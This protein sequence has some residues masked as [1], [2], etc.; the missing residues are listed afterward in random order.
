MSTQ[1]LIELRAEHRYTIYKNTTTGWCVVRF[2][3]TDTSEY[4]VGCG[5]DIPTTTDAKAVLYGEWVENP[6]YGKQFNVSFFEDILPT[7]MKGFISYMKYLKCHI[8]RVKA[9]AI[10]AAFGEDV[11]NVIENRPQELLAITKP[12]ITQANVDA[13]VNALRENQGVRHVMNLFRGR[14]NVTPQKARKILDKLGS[15]AEG[16]IM[17]EPYRLCDYSGFSFKEVD[18][19]A[20]SSGAVNKEARLVAAVDA[21]L[22]DAATKGHVCVPLSNVRAMLVNYLKDTPSPIDIKTA[23]EAVNLSILRKRTVHYDGYLYSRR[24]NEEEA[25]VSSNITA[26]LMDSNQVEGIDIFIDQYQKDSGVM[27]AEKQ[28]EGVRMALRYSFSVLTGGPGTGKT[29]TIR[30]ILKVHQLVYGN[31][32]E[33]VL[34]APTGKAARRMSE[35]AGALATT[36]HSAISY[37]GDDDGEPKLGSDETLEGN[38]FIVDEVSMLDQSIAKLLLQKIPADARVVFVGDPDQLPPVGCGRILLDLINSGVVPV[39]KLDVIYRQGSDSPIIRNAHAINNGN[40]YEVDYNARAFRF[41]GGNIPE[42]RIA[43]QAVNLYY[44]C[45]VEYGLDNVV[46]LCPYRTKTALNVNYFN[47]EL[48]ARLNPAREGE[49]TMKVKS[50]EFRTGDRVMQLKNTEVAKNGDTGYIREIRREIDTDDPTEYT[51]AAY[52]EW[53]GEGVVHRYSLESLQYVDLAYCTTVHKSQGSEYKTVLL[54]CSSLH[55]AML[56]RNVLYTGVTRAKQNVAIIGDP[57]A[58]VAS[59]NN[60]TSDVRWTLLAER[61]K[62]GMQEANSQQFHSYV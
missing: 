15:E 37:I 31:R 17:C 21:L 36:I 34:L 41:I 8:G 22:A 9:T 20:H 56:K 54:I 24:M 46:L 43:Q 18:A 4:F 33:P 29:T 7:T 10:Y 19:L 32:S 13:L 2:L 28:A 35:A 5:N 42:E 3:V 60:N 16:I 48:Q 61:L 23:G 52:I 38:L 57:G 51:F 27:L 6:Q 49:F 14:C 45:A 55:K 39:T 58:F 53:N 25:F 44:R 50:V 62:K 11:W 1:N 59:V 12:R 40:L 30:A 26:R 47:R